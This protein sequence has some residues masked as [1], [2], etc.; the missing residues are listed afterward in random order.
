MS[1]PSAKTFSRQPLLWL[2]VWFAVGILIAKVLVTDSSVTVVVI[3]LFAFAAFILRGKVLATVFIAI[4]FAVLGFLSVQAERRSVRPDRLSVLYDNGTFQSG[5]P[6]EV[7]GVLLGR[8]EAAV[9][10]EILTLRAEKLRHRGADHMV[11]GQVRL[12]ALRSPESESSDLRSEISDLKY[13]SRIRVACILERED[14]FLN[15]G[16]ITRREMLDRLGIDATGSVKSRLLIEHIADESVFLPLAWVYDQR[17]N[18]IHEFRRNLSPKAAGVMIA[19]LLGNKYFLDK[20]TADLFRDGGTFHILVISGLHITFIGGILL[21]IMR[22]ITRNR[23]LQFAV[24]NCTLWAYTLAVGADVPVVRAALMFTVLLFGYAIYRRG[25]LLNSLGLCGLILLVW[26]P[27][28]LFDPSFQLTFVSV[29]AIVACAYPV[30]EHLR[31]IGNWT[32]S[33][34]EPFPPNVPIWLKRFCE[35]LYWNADAWQ[36]EAKRQIWT[37]HVF[38]SPFAQQRVRGAVQHFVRSVFEG[39][40]VSLIVQLWMLPLTVVYFHRISIVSILLNLWVGFLIAIESFA[41]VAGMIAG[42]FSTLLAAGFYAM[43]DAT[44]WLML[45]VPRL[46]SDGGWAS[47]RIP[48]YTE[49]GFAAYLIYFLPILFTA[50]AVHKWKPFAIAGQ[51]WLLGWKNIAGAAAALIVLIGMIVF[52]PLSVNVPDGRLHIDFL[53]VGQGDAALITFPNGKTMLVDGG[54]R[55]DY[56]RKD[57]DA[58]G[59]ERDTRGIGEAVVSEVLWAIGYSRIDVV[60]TTHAD[61]DH[62]QGLIDVA[63]NFRV[64]SVIFARMPMNDADVTELNE[65]LRQ[66]KIPAEIV[67]RG[68]LLRF[69]E[70]SVEIL[71]PPAALNTASNNDSSIVMRIVYGSRSFLLTGDIE[72]AGEMEL[73]ARGGTIH[74]DLVKVPHH[75]SRTSSTSE[76]VDA[77]DVQ[78]A[79]I[80]VGRR[81]PF[82]HPHT[83]VV[84]WWKAAGAKVLTTGEKGMISVSTDGHDLRFGTFVP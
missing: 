2:A 62:I 13:G 64:G 11:S 58:D 12:L 63:K 14:E 46:F 3:V 66:R 56:R 8:P 59:F 74:A 83:E 5:S 1:E 18:I 31:E 53:D 33:S 78:Y 82:G 67:S 4:A 65:V 32:P 40:L 6:V 75:G 26:R 49:L 21:L 22:Q 70:V 50:V 34:A 52:H 41:A 47:F 36:V 84:E 79:V 57:E 28:A 25:G 51:E 35:M 73:L 44:N 45:T 7:E 77:V 80:S 16:V 39:L 55:F 54:G 10:G 42:Y 15:P 9:D 37:A 20:D 38:K 43:A 24:T 71:H 72:R 27:S 19:S 68:D 60:V 29:A 61:A 48:A 30:I 69:G 23:W 81:S 76:L 17:A